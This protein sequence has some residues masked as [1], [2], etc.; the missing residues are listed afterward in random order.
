MP[1]VARYRPTSRRPAVLAAG[2]AVLAVISGV[3][4]NLATDSVPETLAWARN[5]WLLWGTVALLAVVAAVLAV[6]SQ[7]ASDRHRSA[8]AVRVGRP[9]ETLTD[10]VA[11]DLEVHR[12]ID[13]GAD[14][15]GLGPLP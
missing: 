8:R 5:P 3:V 9:I 2:I 6:W 1:H 15:V 4:V 13:A 11:L 14:A 7:R 12:A 10:P